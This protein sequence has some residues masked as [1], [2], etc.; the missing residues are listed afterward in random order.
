MLVATTPSPDT[1]GDD[2]SLPA[3]LPVV[4]PTPGGALRPAVADSVTTI[5]GQPFS[6]RHATWN[7]E[8]RRLTANQGAT[9]IDAAAS[10]PA[11]ERAHGE[12]VLF[13]VQHGTADP[14]RFVHPNL[15]GHQVSYWTAEAAFVSGI[16]IP[17]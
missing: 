14:G 11:A 3:G 15:L 6:A 17:H 2:F 9:L 1:A 12:Q 8:V 10:W 13:N 7:A 16:R 4:Y 5:D